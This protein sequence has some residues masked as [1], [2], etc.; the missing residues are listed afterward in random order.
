MDKKKSVIFLINGLGIE[1]PGSY[2]IAIDEVMPNLCKTKE[3]SYFTSAIIS[4]LEYR[5]AYQ[6]FFLGDTYKLELDYINKNLINENISNN[7]TYQKMSNDLKNDSSKLH[8]FV[9]P[10]NNKV[11][12]QI[13]NLVN[14]LPLTGNKRVYLHLLLSQQ[15]IAEYDNLISIINYIK[16]H[17]NEHITVGFILGK[18][19]L[20][21]EITKEELDYTKKLLF[22]CSAERWSETEKKLQLLKQANI[23]P[24]EVKGFCTN[25]DC[26]ISNNDVILFFN[27]RRDN[28]DNILT[29]IYE[30]SSVFKEKANLHIYSLIK[31]YSKYDIVSFLDNVIYDNSLAKLLEKNGKKA[32]IYSDPK[33]MRLVNFYA[34]GLNSIN[35]PAI[36]F[37]NKSDDLYNKEYIN[38]LINQTDFDLFIF[39]YHMDVSST[40]NNLKSQLSKLDIIIGNLA[41]CCVNKNSLFISS[42][43]GLKKEL[44]LADY[45]TDKVLINYEMQIPIF[46]FDYTYPRS[47]Y[48][49]FPGETNDILLSALKCIVN[50]P[51]IDSLVRPKTFVGSLFK[52]FMR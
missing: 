26:F 1:K 2:S 8:V 15:T 18:E 5:T 4:S 29:S 25:N 6:R 37:A 31:L 9:E 24:C 34:N 14:T 45:N 3:T 28:Y 10:T 51:E 48:D 50:D 12:D 42:L 33:N 49:L 46:F 36:C 21:E 32:L 44:P 38:N 27:T 41:D 13:N 30:N 39:D 22:M 52:T 17:L 47:K 35:N 7:T 20:S 40:I 19:S 43:Y 23:R 16:F 11:V